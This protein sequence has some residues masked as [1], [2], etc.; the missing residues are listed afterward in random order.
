[1]FHQLKDRKKT[2]KRL[3]RPSHVHGVLF[4]N[5]SFRFV[6]SDVFSL[7]RGRVGDRDRRR[8]RLFSLHRRRYFYDDEHAVARFV[9]QTCHVNGGF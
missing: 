9:V 7:G 8:R 5:R 4:L 2:G 3:Y 1:M 6:H